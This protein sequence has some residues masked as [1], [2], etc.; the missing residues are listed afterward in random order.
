VAAWR[1]IRV[2]R[3]FSSSGP[4]A[5]SATAAATTLPA[6]GGSGVRVTRFADHAQDAVAVFVPQVA[7]VQAGGFENPQPEQSEQDGQGE[8]KPVRRGAG[9]GQEGFELQVGLVVFR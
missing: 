7:D 9:R 8:V 4:P 1:S 5:G 3:A 6:A 2:P